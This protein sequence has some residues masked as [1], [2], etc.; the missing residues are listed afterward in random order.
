VLPAEVLG[1]T[2]PLASYCVNRAVTLFGQCIDSEIDDAVDGKKKGQAEA[3]A[4]NVL[5][6]WLGTP[7]KFAT[8][9]PTRR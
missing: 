3:A 4:S 5:N 2:D 7:M 9:T 6:K 1:V 8:P